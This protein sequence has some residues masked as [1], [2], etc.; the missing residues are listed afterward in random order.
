MELEKDFE[1]L[2]NP[3]E[4]FDSLES[5]PRTQFFKGFL[6]REMQSATPLMRML[7]FQSAI[8]AHDLGSAPPGNALENALCATTSKNNS[9]NN[10]Y[11]DVPSIR[12][13][14]KDVSDNA[15]CPMTADED[16]L[17]R[18]VIPEGETSFQPGISLSLLFFLSF[19]KTDTFAFLS[20]R[21]P[22]RCTYS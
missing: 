8:A 1:G 9:N 21:L 12:I 7:M 10:L 17:A 18:L 22:T 5:T 14:F 15:A 4:G 11:E 3:G 13:F 2:A 20:C 6:C 16:A 19:L